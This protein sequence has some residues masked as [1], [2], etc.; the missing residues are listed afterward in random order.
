[1]SA[2]NPFP[3]M[4]PWLEHRWGDVHSRL[5]IYAG[6]QLQEKLPAGLR[7]RMQERVFLESVEGP[8]RSFYPDVS[9]HEQPSRYG[10]VSGAGSATVTAPLVLHLPDTE[11]TEPFLEIIDAGSGGRIVTIIE[12]VSRSNKSPGEGRELYVQKQDECK[13]AAVNLVEIDLLRSGDPVT[14]AHRHLLNKGHRAPWHVSV[15]RAARSAQAECYLAAFREPLPVIAVPLR[16]SDADVPLDLQAL[17]DL[18]HVRGK[19]DD[20]DYSRPLDPPLGRE[21][22]AWVESLLRE[23]SVSSRSSSSD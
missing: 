9:I 10:G 16:S 8:V 20:I 17:I 11:I 21:E 19:Y 22:T 23:R 13:S 6:D 1:M 2:T 12:V 3:G 5:V 15:W 4:N 18:C 14:I 7:A